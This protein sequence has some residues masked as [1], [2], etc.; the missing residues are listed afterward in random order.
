MF[1]QSLVMF[2]VIIYFGLIFFFLCYWESIMHFDNV[3]HFSTLIPFGGLKI[4]VFFKGGNKEE[5][6]N[7]IREMYVWNPGLLVCRT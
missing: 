1:L 2:L 7:V 6:S 4:I 3:F 5:L